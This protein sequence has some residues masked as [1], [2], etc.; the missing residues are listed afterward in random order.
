MNKEINYFSPPDG[1]LQW[2]TGLN[3]Q[4]TNFNYATSSGPHLRL[5]KYNFHFFTCEIVELA[6][7]VQISKYIAITKKVHSLYQ[8]NAVN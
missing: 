6:L 7:R 2:H 4:I 8:K 1:C 5:L 3:G